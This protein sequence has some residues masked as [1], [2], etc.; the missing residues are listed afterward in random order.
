METKISSQKEAKDKSLLEGKTGIWIDGKIYWITDFCEK[1]IPEKHLSI[2]IKK[3]VHH[4]KIKLLEVFV[5]NHETVRK[6]C[7]LLFMNFAPEDHFCFISPVDDV[8]FHCVRDQVYLVNGYCSGRH[9]GSA[10][11]Q[12]YWNVHTDFIWS[13]LSKGILKYQ[14]MAKG[15][16]VSI[17]SMEMSIPGNKSSVG[18]SWTIRGKEKDETMSLNEMFM[19]NVL[20]IPYKK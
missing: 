8:I 11:V 15:M 17:F 19:K 5:K 2:H 14:P 4:S 9:M 20:A 16:V 10:T 13:S 1:L 12:P 3:M 18:Y 6:N 7:K